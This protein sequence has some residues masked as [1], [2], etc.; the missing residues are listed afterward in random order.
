MIS[1]KTAIYGVGAALLVT[2]LAAANM[3]GSETPAPARAAAP[4]PRGGEALADEVSAQASRLRTRMAGAPMPDPQSRNP[5]SFA[6]VRHAERSSPAPQP[7]PVTAMPDVPA[8]PMLTL[9]GVAEETLAQ[10]TRRTAIIGADADALYMVAEGDSIGE[11]Y[12]VTKI[13]VD[14]VELEDLVTH[15]YRRLALR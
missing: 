12:K 7:D 3:P 10:G 13:G 6:P 1:A 8:P 14:A 5:F 2:Y 4:Q 15:A 9:M 11:R